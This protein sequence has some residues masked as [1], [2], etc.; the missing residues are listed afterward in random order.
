MISR[1]FLMASFRDGKEVNAAT[2]ADHLLLPR[3]GF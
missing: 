2:C 3:I 1:F